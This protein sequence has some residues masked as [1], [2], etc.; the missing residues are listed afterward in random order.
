M[1]E[2]GLSRHFWSSDRILVAIVFIIGL[3]I[4]AIATNQLIDPYLNSGKS[5]DYNAMSDLVTRLNERNDQLF[6]CLQDNGIDAKS[7]PSG[8]PE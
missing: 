7:C 6:Q 8:E 3:A 1:A 5:A 4:G 2:E